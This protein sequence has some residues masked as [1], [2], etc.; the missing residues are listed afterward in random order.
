[1]SPPFRSLDVGAF[2]VAG[3]DFGD[4]QIAARGRRV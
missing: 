3:E 1:M 4:D 2:E